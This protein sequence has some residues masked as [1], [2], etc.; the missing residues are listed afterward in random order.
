MHGGH[1]LYTYV[2]FLQLDDVYYHAFSHIKAGH[3]G[4]FQDFVLKGYIRELELD[5][6]D[7]ISLPCIGPV[8]T[9]HHFFQIS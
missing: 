6:E 1:V 4:L 2:Q 8:P 5:T 9:A 7:I 3:P